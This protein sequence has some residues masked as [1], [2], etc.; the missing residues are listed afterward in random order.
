MALEAINK[1][2]FS[3]PELIN[4]LAHENNLNQ[5][6]VEACAQG[7][8]LVFNRYKSIHEPSTSFD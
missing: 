6:E 8:Q 3:K 1:N 4:Q 5:C 7:A 2:S